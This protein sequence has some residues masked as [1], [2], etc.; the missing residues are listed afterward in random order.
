MHQY[1]STRPSKNPG[2]HFAVR[3]AVLFAGIVGLLHVSPRLSFAQTAVP[4]LSILSD[5]DS[6]PATAYP[7]G[8]VLAD[9]LPST[10]RF[11]APGTRHTLLLNPARMVG[12]SGFIV[13]QYLPHG[14]GDQQVGVHL[15]TGGDNSWLV[16]ITGS[17]STVERSTSGTIDSNQS[18][19]DQETT[20]LGSTTNATLRIAR[21]LSPGRSSSLRGAVGLRVGLQRKDAQQTSLSSGSSTDVI[22][23]A[24]AT[25]YIVRSTDQTTM[26]VTDNSVLRGGLEASLANDRTDILLAL[27]IDY[28]S[29]DLTNEDFTETTE[30]DSIVASDQ[31]L[32]QLTRTRRLSGASTTESQGIPGFSAGVSIRHTIAERGPARHSIVFQGGGNWAPGSK[33]RAE[34]TSLEVEQLSIQNNVVIVDESTGDSVRVE[35]TGDPVRRTVFAQGAYI[36]QQTVGKIAITTGLAATTSFG[37]ERTGKTM[38]PEQ[39]S[40]R[41]VDNN[42]NWLV[43]AFLNYNLTRSVS[44]FAGAVFDLS[45]VWDKTTTR[46]GLPVNGV[47]RTENR[48][49]EMVASYRIGAMID[50]AGYYGQVRFAGNLSDYSLWEVSLGLDL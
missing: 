25:R 44:L 41:K 40:S 13:S 6:N 50:Q 42:I 22:G 32:A 7:T 37:L 16:S 46:I 19:L 33:D 28:V 9:D 24:N 3:R 34:F 43:P 36:H 39:R 14:N 2:L 10:F 31:S 29:A 17:R 4:E 35:S 11:F 15:V 1:Y 26:D 20:V 5:V 48:I 30:V 18:Q 8:F 21:S 38:H 12:E 45:Y 27:Q 23:L 49:G 47:Q